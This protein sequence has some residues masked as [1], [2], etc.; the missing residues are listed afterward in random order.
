MTRKYLENA[1]QDGEEVVV[2]NSKLLEPGSLLKDIYHKAARI[3]TARAVKIAARSGRHVLTALPG[4]EAFLWRLDCEIRLCLE[5]YV[6]A[7]VLMPYIRG[8]KFHVNMD[9]LRAGEMDVDKVAFLEGLI[10][11]SELYAEHV[12]TL[13]A[14]QFD[15]LNHNKEV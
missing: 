2:L 15:T 5:P 9:L 14:F 12:G 10:V 8:L 7:G 4:N 3:T 6:E 1:L 11:D 13:P